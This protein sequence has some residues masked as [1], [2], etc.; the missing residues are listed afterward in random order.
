MRVDRLRSKVEGLQIEEDRQTAEVG[1][2]IEA[3]P[4]W[5]TAVENSWTGVE[6]TEAVELQE[7]SAIAQSV[8]AMVPASQAL[9]Q[10]ELTTVR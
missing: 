6:P 7:Q 1:L 9:A 3:A 2:Q 5:R 10:H 4:G 8:W